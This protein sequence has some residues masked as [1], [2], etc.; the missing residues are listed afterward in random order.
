MALACSAVTV[1]GYAQAEAASAFKSAT[2][3][4]GFL[5][6]KAPRGEAEFFYP[7][8]TIYL[9]VE[10]KG[11]PKTGKVGTTFW[12]REDVIAR[13]EVDVA[14]VNKGVEL[15][16][17]Q[18]TFAGFN[19]THD[20][21]LPVGDC[22]RAVVTLDGAP[23]GTFPFRVAPPKLALPTKIQTVTLSKNVDEDKRPV[24][25][26]REFDSKDKV[27]L[28]GVGNLGLSTWLEVSWVL[29]G[30]TDDSGTRSI[31]MKENKRDCPFFFSFIP[32]GGWPAGTHE[33]VLH[34]NC[35]E[36][37]REKFTI[38]NGPALSMTVEPASFQLLK[39]DGQGEPSEVVEAY[40]SQDKKFH[41]AWQ[42]NRA[43]MTQD[44][45]CVWTVVEAGDTKDQVI[46]TAPVPNTIT[47]VVR[48]TLRAKN[49][50]PPGK[51]KVELFQKETLLDSHAFE[52]K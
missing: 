15:S 31:T 44:V 34:V 2:F 17:G 7:D 46:A 25:E 30:V 51:F 33:V 12:F 38:T 35:A 14:T 24:Q 1:P 4:H 9:S 47:E 40:T 10:L 21:P 18:S 41:A 5:E 11:R 52:V 37:R 36:V 29:G 50:L 26:T 27:V 16:V 28:S 13:A 42:L 22:Y 6:S 20:D 23:L 32:N 43:A 45:R 48:G 19:L 39:D 49:G 3:C 8:Q